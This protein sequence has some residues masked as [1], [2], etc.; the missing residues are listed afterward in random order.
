MAEPDVDQLADMLRD[1]WIVISYSTS[2]M[3]AGAMAHSILL[4]R[5]DELASVSVIRAN[6]KELGRT[7]DV[8][9]PMPQKKGWL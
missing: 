7:I 2:M 1:G 9:S 4:Q 3:A 8:L 5:S 6:G